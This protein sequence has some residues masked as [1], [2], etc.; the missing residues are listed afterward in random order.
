[1]LLLIISI[2]TQITGMDSKPTLIFVDIVESDA[3]KIGNVTFLN[4]V[5]KVIEL[6]S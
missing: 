4:A 5:Y 6:M 1:M 3:A 2:F